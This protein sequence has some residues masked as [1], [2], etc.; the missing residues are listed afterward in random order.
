VQCG[1]RRKHGT[2]DALFTMQHLLS[3][4]RHHKQLLYV[5]YVDFRKAFDMARREEMLARAQQL[6]MHGQFL[7]ALAQWLHNSRLA[8]HVGTQQGPAFNTYR[9]TKQ[10]GRLSPLLFGMFIEQLH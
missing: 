2:L 1:F 3:R 4:C 6:G 8:V 9:G 7:Q 10:G 5:C